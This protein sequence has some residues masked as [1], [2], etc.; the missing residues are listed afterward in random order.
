MSKRNIGDKSDRRAVSA[1]GV[2]IGKRVR[3]AREVRG[4]TARA[5]AAAV[6]LPPS[7]I[8]N[9]E[10]GRVEPRAPTLSALGS[11]LG[12]AP[13]SLLPP[14]PSG[15]REMLVARLEALPDSQLDDVERFLSLLERVP[16]RVR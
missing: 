4:M 8:S 13:G 9:L 7:H 16:T 6:G 1:L 15:S 11:A 14:G 3:A 5:L 12:V 10:R 2:E